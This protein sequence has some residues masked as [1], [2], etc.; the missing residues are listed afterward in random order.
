M[1][2][3]IYSI[4]VLFPSINLSAQQTILKGQI[5]DASE[6]P[7][8]YA[9]IAVYA[10]PEPKLIAGT[11]SDSLGNFQVFLPV[12]QGLDSVR[13]T[14]S[15][16]GYNPLERILTSATDQ[17]V[18]II[19]DLSEKQLQEI[20]VNAR[21]NIVER[22]IDRTVFYVENS[23]MLSETS[24]WESLGK[25]SGV[26]TDMD[27]N[28]SVFGKATQVY[29]DNRPL[30][31][32]PE[33]SADFLRNLSSKEVAS[34]E[35]IHHP[36][37]SYDAQGGAIVNI[38]MKR[39]D[40]SGWNMGIRSGYTQATYPK[41]FGGAAFQYKNNRISISANY[42]I[43]RR[44]DYIL[45]DGYIQY[46]EA[47]WSQAQNRLNKSSSY[48][49]RVNSDYAISKQHSVGVIIDS[50]IRNNEV[51]STVSTTA[52]RAFQSGIDSILNTTQQG[53]SR[54][55]AYS[56]NLHY[57]GRFNRAKN[58][59]SV[60]IDFSPFADNR[61]RDILNKTTLPNGTVVP[62]L[63]DIRQKVDQDIEI[64]SLKSDFSM[65]VSLFN[66][67]AKFETG[68]KTS[69]VRI[70][71][72]LSFFER[73]SEVFPDFPNTLNL[74]DY[75]ENVTA[76]YINFQGDLGAWNYQLGARGEYTRLK[77]ISDGIE[78]LKQ[79]YFRLFPS[80]YIVYKIDEEKQLGFSYGSRIIRPEFWRLNPFRIYNN[81]YM[82]TEGNPFLQPEIPVNFEIKYSHG[83][84]C[85]IGLTYS[86]ANQPIADVSL[87]N[88]ENLRFYNTY[89]NLNRN[90]QTGV[91]LS[92]TIDIGKNWQSNN[93]LQV[94]YKNEQAQL[95]N[96]SYKFNVWYAYI[97]SNNSFILSENKSWM[98]EFNIWYGSPSIVGFQKLGANWDLSIV[99][100]KT[101][102]GNKA[103]FSLI[104]SDIFYKNINLTTI[105]FQDQN[106]SFRKKVD[107]R[108]IGLTFSY[109]FGDTALKESR[110]RKTAAEDEKR[111]AAQ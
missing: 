76:S 105:Q 57:V 52:Y 14:I 104:L 16:I 82:Y 28:I 41:Y 98:G 63:F 45:E 77:G 29:I 11:F 88:N 42:R 64:R 13:L 54:Q 9:S 89:S 69:S 38:V 56:A 47:Y 22:K 70:Q 24:L 53:D 7:V 34:I 44:L 111:R 107:S 46:R 86:Y 85:E 102:M 4:F 84:T 48:N 36:P 25:L 72:Q 96:A 59:L 97:S 20:V 17:Q 68:I 35:V 51:S 26:R 80:I 5:T 40:Q 1:K 109:R 74:F 73:Y 101:F 79:E 60:D 39:K 12:I 83:Q 43:A 2:N 103:S 81:P 71:N 19:L 49:W 100:R 108:S 110:P 55:N 95:Y 75:A 33:Q 3:L 67:P 62:T 99:L 32:S 18:E 10:Y 31:L 50:Y 87:Q 8:S 66:R 30:K 61:T 6:S 27:G 94:S 23:A 65:P 106:S 93:L 90:F 58:L 37:A 15:A 91:Y 92:S 78:K 21:K